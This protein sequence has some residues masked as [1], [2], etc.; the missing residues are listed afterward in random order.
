MGIDI[1]AEVIEENDVIGFEEAK[2]FIEEQ[3][4]QKD[5]NRQAMDV[6]RPDPKVI[7]KELVDEQMVA[8]RKIAAMTNAAEAAYYKDDDSISTLGSVTESLTSSSRSRSTPLLKTPPHHRTVENLFTDS[9]S[10]T[11][12]ITMESFSN[13]QSDVQGM[14]SRFDRMEVLL[15]K[16]LRYHQRQETDESSSLRE[17]QKTGGLSS[18]SGKA[19]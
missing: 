19:S 2:E 16:A 7:S 12:S 8:T 18:H 6:D 5:A 14:K 4:K 1:N 15:E 13:L 3:K 11:S 9:P 17:G 10:V